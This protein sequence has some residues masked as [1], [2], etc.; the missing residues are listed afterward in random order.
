MKEKLD[1]D[2]RQF[3]SAAVIIVIAASVSVNGAAYVQHENSAADLSQWLLNHGYSIGFHNIV[4]CCAA[5]LMF[6]LW[7]I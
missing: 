4:P 5:L 6:Y 1:Y 2:R 3:Q 7:E